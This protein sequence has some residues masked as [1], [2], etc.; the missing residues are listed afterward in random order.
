MRSKE[1]YT[2]YEE[3][4]EKTEADTVY[5]RTDQQVLIIHMQTGI[6]GRK[7]CHFEKPFTD[8]MKKQR[9]SEKIAN[10]KKLF[11]F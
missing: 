10:D 7:E 3:L 11:I 4:L 8:F 5:I 1:V 2:D 6:I 9:I